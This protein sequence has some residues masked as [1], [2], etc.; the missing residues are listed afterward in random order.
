MDEKICKYLFINIVPLF[1]GVRDN[2]GKQ[3]L[4]KFDSGS[5]QIKPNLMAHLHLL[6]IYMYHGVPNT[7]AVSQKPDNKNGRENF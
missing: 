3:V 6:G 1:P 7:I 2:P 4:L 5:G